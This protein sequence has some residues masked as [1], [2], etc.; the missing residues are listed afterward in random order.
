M[1]F[2]D[3]VP[4]DTSEFNV[5]T[6]FDFDDYKAQIAKFFATV[7]D[8]E[9]EASKEIME[10]YSTKDKH[11]LCDILVPTRLVSKR[12]KY[13]LTKVHYVFHTHDLDEFKKNMIEFLKKVET[14]VML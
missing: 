13:S 14:K 7:L 6:G 12:M 9:P 10:T 5:P 4:T 3:N 11:I 1:G 8:N 2:R